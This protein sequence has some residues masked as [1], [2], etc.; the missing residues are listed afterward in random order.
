MVLVLGVKF[1]GIFL[2]EGVSGEQRQ[3]KEVIM[4]LK[5]S[6]SRSVCQKA[7]PC[8]KFVLIYV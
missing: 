4:E 8:L 3:S 2:L 5:L 6:H 7:A 1:L